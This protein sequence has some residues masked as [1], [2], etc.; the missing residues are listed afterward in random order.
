MSRVLGGLF[1]LVCVVLIGMAFNAGID[2]EARRRAFEAGRSA[3]E[4]S[5]QTQKTPLR[6]NIGGLSAEE[7]ERTYHLKEDGTAT[8]NGHP[9]HLS[10][11]ENVLLRVDS[12]D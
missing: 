2:A 12:L 6:I 5:R 7:I 11:E 1:V 9:Y 4:F 8:H 10:K 3:R